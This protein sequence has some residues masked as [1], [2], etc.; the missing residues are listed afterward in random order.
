MSDKYIYEI[1]L[2]N[3]EHYFGKYANKSIYQYHLNNVFTKQWGTKSE[4]WEEKWKSDIDRV[5]LHNS[6]F[7]ASVEYASYQK[8]TTWFK[9][10]LT[11]TIISL[12][13]TSQEAKQLT[14][15]IWNFI[16]EIW[17]KSDYEN[18]EALAIL[19]GA[20]KFPIANTQIDFMGRKI[21]T[22]GRWAFDEQ[23]VER[24]LGVQIGK[25]GDYYAT[26]THDKA[27]LDV[28][29]SF[30]LS[31]NKKKDNIIINLTKN[32]QFQSIFYK[33]LDNE[34][35]THFNQ[36]I[37]DNLFKR[38]SYY[39]SSAQKTD[40][41]NEINNILK[42]KDSEEFFN[43]LHDIDKHISQLELNYNKKLEEIENNSHISYATFCFI[44]DKWFSNV[45][46]DGIY[47][48]QVD[49]RDKKKLHIS[50]KN[51]FQKTMQSK[52]DLSHQKMKNKQNIDINNISLYNKS[53]YNYWKKDINSFSNFVKRYKHQIWKEQTAILNQQKT[54][55]DMRWY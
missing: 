22:E 24:K 45:G 40:I 47:G 5:G 46:F 23:E 3:K 7:I 1:I 28:L 29:K 14:E 53:V 37:K 4:A 34:I 15:N 41:K 54:I 13:K 9:N 19:W 48:D 26:I 43:K 42:S 31:F 16:K 25:L 51:Y 17:E 30:N 27:D 21:F 55:D 6:N 2:N 36:Q 12:G 52:I 10:T 39:P 35:K 50:Y 32:P 11:D 18:T 44:M 38:L 49:L 33:T 8:I 20:E